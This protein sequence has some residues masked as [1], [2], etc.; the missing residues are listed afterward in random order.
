MEMKSFPF[1]FS[2]VSRAAVSPN[3]RT[4]VKGGIRASSPLRVNRVAWDS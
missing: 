3:P 1:R 2:T 4:A